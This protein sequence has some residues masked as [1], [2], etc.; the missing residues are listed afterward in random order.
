[1]TRRLLVLGHHGQLATAI[2]QNAPAGVSIERAGRD[3]CNMLRPWEVKAFLEAADCEA[4]I[5][6]AA[7]TAV[8]QAESDV[9]NCMMLNGTSVGVVAGVCA[10]RGLPLVHISSDYVFDGAKGSPYDED[11]PCR[12]LGV[13]GYSKWVGERAVQESDARSAILRSSWLFSAYGHNFVKTMMRLAD[14]EV[15]RVVDDQI[16]TPTAAIEVGLAAVAA[17]LRLADDAD[18]QGGLLHCSGEP[19]GSWADLAEAAFEALAANGRSVPR[20]ER[21]TTDQYPSAAVRPADSRLD[22]RRFRDLFPGIV[23]DW[24]PRVAQAV[25]ETLETRES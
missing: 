25:A 22:G 9:L 18:F 21:I 8:D 15:V 17:A 13:Y 7:Y 16:G 19:D 10:E 23:G 1:M 11:D 24:R 2:A 3:E 4:V 5:N 12:P 6:T 14:R 20:F